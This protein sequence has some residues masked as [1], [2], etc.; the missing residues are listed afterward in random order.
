MTPLVDIRR[1]SCRFGATQAL[2]GV[3][4][5]IRAG[6]V[7]CLLGENGAGKSTLG[8][9]LAG[10]VAPSSG[11][12]VLA[13]RHFETGSV[14]AARRA[15]VT[16][17]YQELSLADDLSVAENYHLGR[18]RGRRPWHLLP[19]RREVAECREALRPFGLDGQ[20]H[21][22][23]AGL[24]AGRKQLLEVAK[25]MAGQPQLVVLDE[26]TATLNAVEKKLLFETIR[27]GLSRGISFILITH[28]VDDVL[29]VGDR[30]TLLRNGRLVESFALTPDTG[31]DDILDKLAGPRPAAAGAGA[32]DRPAAAAEAAPGLVAFGGV[33]HARGMAGALSVGRGEVVAVYGVV[34]CGNVEIARALAGVAPDR[35]LDIALQGRRFRPRTPAQARRGGVAYLASKRSEGV[36]GTRSVGENIL[37]SA[38]PAIARHGFIPRARERQRAEELLDAY[39]V[40]RE[41]QDSAILSLSGGNQQKVLIGRAMA[42]AR[43]AVVLEEPTAGIDIGAKRAIHELIRARAAAGMGV[44]LVSSDLSEVMSLADRVYTMFEGALVGEY[45]RPGPGDEAAIIADILGQAGGAHATERPAP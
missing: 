10:L 37:L 30:V 8:K 41:S 18:E 5:Q 21:A 25:S 24:T 26:P 27:Q 38:L 16:L 23:V 29:A 3:S 17:A 22:P 6:E 12:I 11:D 1:L 40:K 7:H 45:A 35:R 34:G 9:I 39:G 19:H 31:P 28:H 33:P 2:D 32:P 14:H 42:V 20:A 43:L 13:G 36:L 44:L 4:L 15:G